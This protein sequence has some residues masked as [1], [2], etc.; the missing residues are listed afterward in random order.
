LI[1]VAPLLG[2]IQAMASFFV[3]MLQHGDLGNRDL[4]TLLVGLS[5]VIKFYALKWESG[6][7]TS[8]SLMM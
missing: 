1:V 5:V 8:P 4:R 7:T 2:G 3:P 6:E